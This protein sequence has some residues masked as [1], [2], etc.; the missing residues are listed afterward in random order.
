MSFVNL[1]ASIQTSRFAHGIA[2]SNHLLIAFFQIVHVFGFIFLLAPLFLIGLRVYRLAL[3]AQP[4]EKVL[5]QGRTLSLIGLSMTLSSGLLMFL[6]APLHY[7]FNWAFD[8]KMGLLLIAILLYVAQFLWVAVLNAWH[9]ALARWS[10]SISLL[11][12]ITV[13]MA[14]RAIGFV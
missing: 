5:Q 13:C 7:Y 9:P 11:S 10:I 1:L 2:E 6:S 3:V 4:L 14:G 12:W 8:V